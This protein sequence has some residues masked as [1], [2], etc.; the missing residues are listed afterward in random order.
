LLCEHLS[1]KR[2]LHFKPPT[3]KY[4]CDAVVVACFD[5]RFDRVLRRF[6]KGIRI[7]NPDPI[8]VAGGAKSLASPDHESD[9]D[10]LVAQ[11][12]K[13]IRLH[14]TDRVILL[15]HSDCGAYGGLHSSFKDDQAAEVSHHRDELRR[16]YAVL[17]GAFPA[18]H[19]ECYF[20][21]FAGVWQL[22][23][24]VLE[25]PNSPFQPESMH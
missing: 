22:E 12:E 5:H 17:K 20:V 19:V 24:A 16:A 13:S 2:I 11:V 25:S 6:L 14:G 9:R 7:V 10:F 1:L 4:H 8:V 21:D 15:L 23:T 18:V 3:L